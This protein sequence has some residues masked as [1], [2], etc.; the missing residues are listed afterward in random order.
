M[1]KRL[2]SLLWLCL[3][4][5]LLLT[6]LVLAAARLWVPT[7]SDYRN[8]IIAAASVALDR[9]VNIR[10]MEA[11]WRGLSPVLKL[12]DVT[13]GG[14]P[15]APQRLD[16]NQIWISIDVQHFLA[17]RELRIS[18]VDVIGIDLTLARDDQGRVYIE[19]LPLDADPGGA[20][21]HL[22][23]M[24]RLTL[25]DASVTLRNPPGLAEPQRF[26]DV[27]LSLVNRGSWH[28]L[29]GY[30]LLPET[31]GERVEIGA[32]LYGRSPNPLDWHGVAYFRGSALVLSTLLHDQLPELLVASGSTDM[33]LWAKLEAGRPVS[34]KGE[35]GVEDLTVQYGSGEGEARFDADRLGTQF[36]WRQQAEGWQL[37]LQ[38]LQFSR[39]ARS[40]SA[41]NLSVAVTRRDDVRHISASLSQL[42]LEVL[43][44]LLTVLPIDD[45]VRM[46]LL[47]LRPTGQMQNLSAS[48]RQ[49]EGLFRVD[50]FDAQFSKLGVA[51]SGPV[52]AL[53]GLDGAVSGA[54]D[55]GVVTLDSH[56]L[57]LHDTRLFRA[58]LLFDR[59]QGEVYWNDTGEGIELTTRGL[60]L[61]NDHL[62]LQGDLFLALPGDQGVAS[63]D[64]QL[65]IPRAEVARIRD[66][67]P[68]EVMSPVG[69]A[70]L[71]RSL[72]GGEVREGSVIIQGP[73][74]RLPYDHG[75]GKLEVRLPVVGATL[76]FN[77]HWSPVT[78]L[79]AQVN[80]TGRQM[81]IHSQAG[82][83]R[84][85]ALHGV[86]AQIRD[87]AHPRLTLRGD[88]KGELS[89]MLA[90]LGS[91]PLGETYGG[92]VD[93]I[94]TT[95]SADLALDIL[96]PLG[97]HADPVTVSGQIG[98]QGNT[99][100]V[101]DN[102]IDL[103]QVR[104]RLEFDTEGI[105]GEGLQATL[106][107]RP[108]QARV[109]TESTN[110]GVTHI[111]LA[112]KLALIE[113]LLAEGHI[114]RKAITDDSDWRV[115]LTG[116]GKPVR[117]K[118]ADLAISLRST[119]AGT[120]IDLPAPLGKPRDSVRE[121]SIRVAGLERSEQQLEFEL[122]GVM[123]GR[124]VIETQDQLAA[125]V[126]RGALAL[127][128][129]EPVLPDRDS[130]LISGRLERF[131]LADWQ[132]YFAAGDA[133]A[134]L[135]L[136]LSMQIGELEMLGH[137]IREAELDI[138]S[139]GR[140]WTIRGRGGPAAGE[141]RLTRTA[142]GIDTVVM[143]LQRLELESVED[144]Q[145]TRAFAPD[146]MPAI[147]ATAQ[148]LVYNGVN[149]GS[150]DLLVEK[151]PGGMV[152]ISRLAMS[153]ETLTLRMSGSWQATEHD[154]LTNVEL[155]VSDARMDWLLE[156]FGYQKVMKGGDLSGSLQANWPGAP[157]AFAADSVEG[158]IRVVIKDGQILEVDPGAGRMLGLLSVTMLPKR[159]ALDFSDLFEKG[160]GFER[161]AGNF[162][163]DA[164]NAYTNDLE[165]DG[166]AA[167]I[168]IS[169]R[170]GLAA[171]DYD[172][173]VTVTPY[174]QSG[175]PLAGTIAG[176][177]AVGAAV[178]VAEKLLGE[179]LG[180]NEIART[181]YTLTGPWS[182]PAIT[183][184]AAPARDA[185][186][187][188]EVTQQDE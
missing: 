94:T 3:V 65:A 92:L 72:T 180:L 171:Q 98:L 80:F 20:G 103:R 116:R 27:T 60:G 105:R 93:R 19:E 131:R 48:L 63:M 45:R 109:W 79:D 188:A 85:A 62:A 126:R 5:M 139:A 51:Q 16:I 30:A 22:T 112:G 99:L 141:A 89:V 33:R 173:L 91:S 14:A 154:S 142:D 161:I 2:F 74:D 87:L 144:G 86:H 54:A 67:L 119:L 69:V 58:P 181:Q 24:S 151:Q 7:L 186:S 169:G 40:W 55:A 163:L 28:E 175:L 108:V 130:L 100:Q 95:G 36:G 159:L 138:E 147:Q 46:Q 71:D 136:Q 172:Q 17:E 122:A 134:G 140:V 57:E 149:Y 73:L 75:E 70:W 38:E 133:S 156:Q 155:E 64:L 104:G 84:S 83:I 50:H 113:Q 66:Y 82:R 34:V 145:Q 150:L 117:G 148:Q 166:A 102:E 182:E 97:D 9:P 124:L 42:D 185:Q 41:E 32:Q 176:G 143:D 118:P 47:A 44:G 111:E 59:L 114:L 90:E 110:G 183:R 101:S 76:D 123:S 43:A 115:R 4:S 12:R 129:T 39:E 178:I 77:E 88:V 152:D 164:G 127:A 8:D 18:G 61:A 121:L 56:A 10:R 187:A 96:V 165:I 179:T 25:H 35:I 153:S 158:K 1:L 132:P 13:I 29:S 26:H 11:T 167:K 146:D 160:F 157:W 107:E 81:D 49:G 37:A 125:R 52:P 15:A 168:D 137:R 120:A 184:L 170:V 78:Q 106:F 68:A 128:G 177:P 21:A 162:V 135:P 23:E 6:A 53:A 174:L 31:I